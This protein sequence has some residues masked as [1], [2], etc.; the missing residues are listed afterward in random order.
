[1]RK[2]MKFSLS[3]TVVASAAVIGTLVGG[4]V[5]AVA[6]PGLLAPAGVASA[7]N[8][9]PAATADPDYPVNESGQTYG[10]ALNATAPEN[11]PDLILVAASNGANGYARKTDLAA[12]EGT[13][14]T[15]IEEAVKWSE[16]DGRNDHKVPVYLSDGKT[17]VGEFIVYG[18]TG[19]ASDDTPTK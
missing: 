9:A 16:G 7:P 4:A 3:A 5:G 18:T 6:V 14:F 10:S 12:A 8:A 2:R 11:E 15:T 13:G 1:M 17:Q 19:R